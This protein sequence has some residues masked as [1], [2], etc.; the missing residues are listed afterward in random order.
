MLC[1][2]QTLAV[3]LTELRWIAEVALEEGTY[4]ILVLD[5][6]FIFC[7]RALLIVVG[8]V[9]VAIHAAKHML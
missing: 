3:N 7:P 4:F 8:D 9:Y 1:Q 6:V 2:S 5:R